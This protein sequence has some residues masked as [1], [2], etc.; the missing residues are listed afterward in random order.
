MSSDSAFTP[1]THH[2]L[3]AMPG[4]EDGIFSRSVIY[5]CEHSPHGAMGLVINKPGDLSM[6]ALF[7]RLDLPLLR[8]DLRSTPVL[9]GGPVHPERGFVLHEPVRMA[10]PG[11]D[12]GDI[13][14]ATLKVPDGLELTTSRDV[15]EAL[16]AGAGPRK[17]LMTLGYAGWGEGQLESE[18]G[19]NTWLTMPADARIV[20]DTPLER[21]YDE[22]LALLGLQTWMLSPEAGHA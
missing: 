8:E 22:A 5:L 11:Q 12:G 9:Q 19:E 10:D 1:L 2:F 7:D 15:L 18:I 20:F 17:V 16:G 3:V 6:R 13:Y 4:L 21:R 14:A